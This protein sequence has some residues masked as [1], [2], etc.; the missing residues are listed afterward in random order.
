MNLEHPNLAEPKE[1]MCIMIKVQ[2]DGNDT[3]ED[4]FIPAMSVVLFNLVMEKYMI[5]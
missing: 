5:K 2:V 4:S 3:K 1:P